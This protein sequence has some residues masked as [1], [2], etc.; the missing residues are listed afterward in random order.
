[1]MEAGKAFDA[2][3]DVSGGMDWPDISLKA[4]LQILFNDCLAPGTAADDGDRSWV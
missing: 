2:S 1:M 3:D 4:E